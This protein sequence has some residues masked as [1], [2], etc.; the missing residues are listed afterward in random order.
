MS[1]HHI[2]YLKIYIIF[3]CQKKNIRIRETVGT[4]YRNFLHYLF[5]FFINLKTSLKILLIFKNCTKG[6]R[7]RG[8]IVVDLYW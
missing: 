2:V 7:K 1:K 4:V 6:E 3:I 5:N 8:G